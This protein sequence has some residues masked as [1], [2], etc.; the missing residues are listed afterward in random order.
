MTSKELYDKYNKAFNERI[1]L[2]N[3]INDYIEKWKNGELVLST[4][5]VE[6][7]LEEAEQ[8][9]EELKKT[10]EEL[11]NEFMRLTVLE[12]Q[13]AKADVSI[14]YKLG[15][16]P[17]EMNITGGVLAPNASDSHLTAEYKTPEQLNSD[18][19][20]Y[21]TVLREKVRNGEISLEQASKV[22]NDIDKSYGFYAERDEISSKHL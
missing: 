16:K 4:E 14:G 13:K 18:K 12:E 17:T 15:E 9:L 7:A 2:E 22:L 19:E 5:L 6:K 8:R 21:E 3:S 11:H 20:H 10:E 1:E